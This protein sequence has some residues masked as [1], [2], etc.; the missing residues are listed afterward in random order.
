MTVP[1]RYLEFGLRDLLAEA[2]AVKVA[3]TIGDRAV[4]FFCYISIISLNPGSIA[5]E[6]AYEAS[7]EATI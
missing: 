4:N 2:M 7:A 3:E 6:I 1:I 5:A